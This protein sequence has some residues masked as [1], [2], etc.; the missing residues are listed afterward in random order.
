MA[1]ETVISGEIAEQD[2]RDRMLRPQRME[3]MVGQRDVYERL[4][5]AV[6]AAVKR[7]EAI[8]HILFDGPPGLGKTTFATCLPREL[9]VGI[10]MCTGPTLK[11]PNILLPYL[12]NLEAHSILFIDEIHRIPSAVEEYLY[13]AM[14]DFRIDFVLGEG[15]SARTI[16]MNL[17]PFTLI[18]ATTRAG[19]LTGPL[20]DRFV[21]R[22]T[23]S[24][25]TVEELTEI[26][27]RSADRLS[28]QIDENAAI[29]L[30]GR[31]RG[32]PRVANNHLRWVRDF[33]TSRGDG[34]ITLDLMKAA[35]QMSGVDAEGLTKQDRRYLQTIISAFSGGPA[36]IEAIAHT[37]NASVDTLTDEVEPFL[38]RSEF[39]LRTPRGRMATAKAYQHLGTAIP[40]SLQGSG[41]KNLF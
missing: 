23:L 27:K 21:I 10:Q 5:I 40:S 34:R 6:D 20:R 2:E 7:G 1:K 3:E 13:T 14:E 33:A 31:S 18:G 28:V 22:E 37:M 36:G 12:T 25:Y 26:L 35:L 39:V 16:N 19:M 4:K 15:V 24:F 38:L 30:A 9:G 32:T 8:G 11:A 29:E 41:Q 17:K